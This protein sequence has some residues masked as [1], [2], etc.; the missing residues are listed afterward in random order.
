[1]PAYVRTKLPGVVNTTTF[2]FS[3]AFTLKNIFGYRSVD[4]NYTFDLD[5]TPLRLIQSQQTTRTEQITNELQASGKLIDSK[6]NWIVGGF[7]IDD[8]PTGLNGQALAVLSPGT[9]PPAVT[10]MAYRH[11]KSERSEE[12]TSEL[13]SLMRSQYA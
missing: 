11:T 8:R 6:L 2:S 1:M 3:D 12:H 9:A 4:I 13:K 5:G 10:A 7:Y